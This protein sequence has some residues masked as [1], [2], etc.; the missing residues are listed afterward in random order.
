MAFT[1]CKNAQLRDRYSIVR[2]LLTAFYNA[3]P[4]QRHPRFCLTPQLKRDMGFTD[5][6]ETH[7][8][9]VQ[10]DLRHPML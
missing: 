7:T 9:P 4:A 3:F 8:K 10:R 2:E 5:I 6:D 1:S